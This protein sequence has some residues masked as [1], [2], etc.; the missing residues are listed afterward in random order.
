MISNQVLNNE[1]QQILTMQDSARD[2]LRR[3][4]A[5]LW[6]IE[7]KLI[8]LAVGLTSGYSDRSNKL[9]CDLLCL[10]LGLV[11]EHSI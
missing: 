9:W 6:V 4:A 11:I 1:S 10:L 2:T 5:N 3:A 8:H 7:S